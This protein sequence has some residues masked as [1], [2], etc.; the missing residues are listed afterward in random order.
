MNEPPVVTNASRDLPGGSGVPPVRSKWGG[1][2]D[3]RP[4]VLALLFFVTG[5][6]GIPLLWMSGSFSLT[7][8]IVWSSVV[9]LYTLLLI[10][11]TVAICWWAYVQVIQLLNGM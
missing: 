11:A 6:F 3:N 8:K 10:G 9:T 7:E 5:F 4:A 1:L 2:L